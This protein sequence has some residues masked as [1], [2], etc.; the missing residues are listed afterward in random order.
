[1]TKPTLSVNEYK[2][3]MQAN[4]FHQAMNAQRRESFFRGSSFVGGDPFA[5]MKHSKAWF[6]YGYPMQVDFYMHWNMYKR[7]GLAA[8]GINIPISLCWLDYP[9]VREGDDE[10]DEE[11]PWELTVKKL[12]KRLKLHKHMKDADRMQMVGRYSALFV[13]VRD[14]LTPDKPLGII[15]LEQII[16]IVPVWEGQLEPHDTDQDPAS[17]RFDRPINYTYS[18]AGT[19]NQNEKASSTFQIHHSRLIMMAEGAVGASIYGEPANEAGFNALLDWD[20]IRGSGGEASWMAAA[21]KQILSPKEGF[22]GAVSQEVVDSIN[23]SLRDMKEGFDEALFLKGLEAKPMGA[24]V[25][26]PKI[27][28]DMALEEYC[29]SRMLPAKIV[30]GTQSGVKAGDEDTAG[31]MR[32]MQSRRLNTINDFYEDVMN[33]FY[34]HGVLVTPQDGHSLEWSD[35]TAPSAMAKID[36]ALKLSQ[37]NKEAVLSGLPPLFDSDEIRKE[38]G[39]KPLTDDIEMPDETLDDPEKPEA[40]NPD[41]N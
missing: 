24:T 38:A 30:V 8:A 19:G 11:T 40:D 41:I 16:E 9:V 36:A 3:L 15:K 37:M 10:N 20:K 28:K 2:I 17:E 6:D 26:D 21:N 34:V 35:L 4:A 22:N 1:M 13:R 39:H 27:Y 23:E 29:A 12:F 18:S 33:W 5:D 31:L 7:N 32:T 14:G 25:P